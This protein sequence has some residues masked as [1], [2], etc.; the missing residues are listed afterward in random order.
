MI[1]VTP[2]VHNK[3]KSIMFFF[4]ILSVGYRPVPRKYPNFCLRSDESN[5]KR[6]LQCS[7]SQNAEHNEDKICQGCLCLRAAADILTVFRSY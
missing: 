4:L 6:S 7:F 3:L 2:M 1:R 5:E